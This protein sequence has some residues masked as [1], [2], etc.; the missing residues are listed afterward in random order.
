MNSDQADRGT[1]IELA[2]V[3]QLIAELQERC[4]YMG[5]VYAVVTNVKGDEVKTLHA[6][7]GNRFAVLG[8]FDCVRQQIREAILKS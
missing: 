8:A 5:C 4:A 2:T 7:S 3:D 6:W 1:P